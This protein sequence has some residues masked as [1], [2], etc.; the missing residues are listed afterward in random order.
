MMIHMGSTHDQLKPFETLSLHSAVK[1]T[2]TQS[3]DWYE[4]T[5][6]RLGRKVNNEA[7]W[8]GAWH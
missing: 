7:L 4:A 8:Q 1:G 2:L 6:R 3:M 5:N